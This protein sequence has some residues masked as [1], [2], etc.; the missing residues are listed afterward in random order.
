MYVQLRN[1]KVDQVLEILQRIH[2]SYYTSFHDI[3]QKVNYGN[4]FKCIYTL[5]PY[6]DQNL[7]DEY[8][9]VNCSL[10]CLCVCMY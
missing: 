2:S 7:L 3:I 6:I 8:S 4:G 1:P 9:K 10:Y 5:C